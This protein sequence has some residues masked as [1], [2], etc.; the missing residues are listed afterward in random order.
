[1]S[2]RYAKNVHLHDQMHIILY[3]K[4]LGT[5][6][7]LKWSS[8]KTGGKIKGVPPLIG[9]ENHKGKQNHYP[10]DP[11]EDYYDKERYISKIPS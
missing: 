7:A 8:L 5:D 3:R 6:F 9:R 10:R 2:G 4:W 1:M 11:R